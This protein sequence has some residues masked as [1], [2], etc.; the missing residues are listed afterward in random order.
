MLDG[1]RDCE[2][3]VLVI[4]F[5]CHGN[6]PFL[7]LCL[8]GVSTEIVFFCTDSKKTPNMFTGLPHMVLAVALFTLFCRADEC[9]LGS[10]KCHVTQRGVGE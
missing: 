5:C 2:E 1:Q 4:L 7:L 6:E 10:F 3:L 8:Y 9:C